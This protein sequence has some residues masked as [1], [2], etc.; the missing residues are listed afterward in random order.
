MTEAV[1]NRPVRRSLRDPQQA[2]KDSAA[3]MTA[4]QAGVLPDAVK[5]AA[6][7]MSGSTQTAT[8]QAPLTDSTA[9]SSQ[10]RKEQDAL[11]V[12]GITQA[13][14]QTSSAQVEG[15]HDR[16]ALAMSEEG[17]S[18]SGQDRQ[19][20]V[21]GSTGDRQAPAE[22][23]HERSMPGSGFEQMQ[24]SAKGSAQPADSSQAAQVQGASRPLAEKEAA[25]AGQEQLPQLEKLG[26]QPRASEAQSHTAALV[27][28]SLQQLNQ[29]QATGTTLSPNCDVVMFHL[30]VPNMYSSRHSVQQYQVPISDLPVVL[31]VSHKS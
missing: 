10:A 13:G 22:G 27:D 24:G 12:P 23:V 19:P 8:P 15:T 31:Q 17:A 14:S 30:R 20:V 16:R 26:G 9:T 1:E 18:M 7:S 28:T 5:E 6:G 25:Y 21:R 4:P 11:T 2:A 3:A 29:G